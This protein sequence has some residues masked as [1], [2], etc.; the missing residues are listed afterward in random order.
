VSFRKYHGEQGGAQHG[1]SHLH[2]PGTMEGFP[3]A[4]PPGFVPNLK[5][6]EVEDLDLRKDFRSQMFELWDPAQKIAFDD[7]SDKLING[8]YF[9]VK[10]ADIWD[11][12]HKHYRIWLEWYQVYGMLPPAARGQ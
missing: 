9:L 4:A 8:W 6:E 12:E 10:R 7:I 2:W 3:V 11:E 5:K 1:N